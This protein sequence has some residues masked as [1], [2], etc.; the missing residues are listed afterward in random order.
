ML[1]LATDSTVAAKFRAFSIFLLI[2][3]FGP[4]AGL[5]MVTGGLQQL[6][7]SIHHFF[8]ASEEGVTRNRW[9]TQLTLSQ[10]GRQDLRKAAPDV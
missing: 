7:G 10:E 2:V 8:F 6:Q 1:N 3:G 4:L 9:V 5:V